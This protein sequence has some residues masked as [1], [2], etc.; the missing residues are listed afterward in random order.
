MP[1]EN[2]DNSV[3]TDGRPRGVILKEAREKKRLSLEAVHEATKIPLDAIRA[4]EEGYSI[5]TLST[6]Y[7]R[8]F[9]KI[10]ARYLNVD[11]RL[12]LG[13]DYNEKIA[14][15]VIQ[16]RQTQPVQDM[17]FDRTLGHLRKFLTSHQA[18]QALKLL[19]AV[20]AI[21]LL[22]KLLGAF[23]HSLGGRPKTE[24]QISEIKKEKKNKQQK[25]SP[26]NSVENTKSRTSPATPSGSPQNTAAETKQPAPLPASP[27]VEK[28]VVLTARAK[29][30]SWLTVKV[31]GQIVFQ[32][33]LKSGAA[34]TW[35][36]DKEVEISGKNINRLEFEFNGKMIGTL[37]RRD[38][39]AQ[40]V[41]VTKDGLSVTK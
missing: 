32:S 26:D 8:G 39:G 1:T 4:I 12:V 3:V 25:I 2:S 41:I 7:L 15:P 33:T 14:R 27:V 17:D 38:K 28:N 9:I 34:E 30:D 31:D 35:R 20:V 5:R 24:K 18:R 36:A 10:Y 13:E 19:G 16:P 40:K 23:F 21:F 6:F 37:G 29:A 22:F 11:L